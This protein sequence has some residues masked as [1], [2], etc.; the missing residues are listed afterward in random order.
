MVQSAFNQ[1]INMFQMPDFSISDISVLKNLVK[2]KEDFLKDFQI[3]EKAE[4]ET[5]IKNL[6]KM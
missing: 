3:I 4:E 1:L 5:V 2:L 6:L